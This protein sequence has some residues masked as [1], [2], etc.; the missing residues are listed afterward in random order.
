MTPRVRKTARTRITRSQ[1]LQL[2]F[3]VAKGAGGD[4]KA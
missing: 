3:S 1:K 4:K 2:A